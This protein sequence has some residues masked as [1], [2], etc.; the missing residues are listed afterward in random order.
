MNEQLLAGQP[1]KIDFFYLHPWKLKDIINPELQYYQHLSLIF[2]RE[3]DLG[4]PAELSEGYD[5]FDVIRAR[6]IIGEAFAKQVSHTLGTFTKEEVIFQNNQFKINGQILTKQHWAKIKEILAEE[7]YIDLSVLGAK[8]EDYN[9]ANA[10]AAEFK[11]RIEETKKLVRKYKKTQQVSLGALVNRLCAKSQ[12]INL[13]N[14][15]DYTFYQF[16]QHLDATLSIESYDFNMS[17]LLNGRIDA[18]KQKIV[19]WTENK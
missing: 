3:E 7:N 13:L 5:I 14:V 4:W 2:A 1:I 10:K 18:K 16:K 8:E 15:W 17:A 12:N 9:F 19:H 11:K 6:C